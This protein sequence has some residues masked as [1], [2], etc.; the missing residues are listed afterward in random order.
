MAETIKNSHFRRR[1]RKRKRISVGLYYIVHIYAMYSQTQNSTYTK[2]NLRTVKWAQWV[3]TQSRPEEGEGNT[4]LLVYLEGV[5][6]CEVDGDGEH[7]RNE[8]VK[9]LG[10][11]VAQW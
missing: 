11:D 10:G 5:G 6:L 9:N 3:K 2:M 4:L 7:K 8:D 1:K